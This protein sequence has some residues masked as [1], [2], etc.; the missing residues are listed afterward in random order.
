[1]NR[2]NILI[3]DR[4]KEFMLEQREAFAPF[5]G[6][7]QLAFAT[8]V[9]KATEILKK[10]SVHLVLANVRLA[11]ESGIDL[12]L[13][14]HRWHIGTHVV[15]YSNDLTEELKR[16]AY[17]SGVSAILAAPFGIEEVLRIFTRIFAKEAGNNFLE[18]I[19][20]ADLLQLIGMGNHCTDV[21]VVHQQQRGIIRIRKGNLLEAETAEHRG[22][23]A[24]V[25]MPSWKE[26]RITPCKAKAVP[27][28]AKNKK[29]F[30]LRDVLMQA[31]TRLDEQYV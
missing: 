20:L 22:V 13:H 12:L 17:H 31:V 25:E 23:D 18:S 28:S 8:N 16:L 2:K 10:F 15:L 24:I 26:P 5:S 11:G 30:P 27:G 3:V 6:T 1:M 29:T 19:H 7:Y 14:V 21:I 9:A 4:D